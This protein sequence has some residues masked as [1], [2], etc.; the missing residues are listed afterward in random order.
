MI[1]NNITYQTS[2]N[3]AKT[4]AE[5]LASAGLH[6]SNL[7][8]GLDFTN[9]NEWPRKN[10]FKRQSLHHIGNGSN[11]YEQAIS[12]IGKTLAPFDEDNLIPCFGFG[13]SSTHD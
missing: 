9:C 1:I 10:S 5:Y 6:S 13:D 8:L 12:I 3:E 4:V 2:F 7:I 11:P